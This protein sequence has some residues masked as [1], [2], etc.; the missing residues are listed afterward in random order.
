[1]QNSIIIGGR[2]TREGV[3]KKFI[4]AFIISNDVRVYLRARSV[5]VNFSEDTHQIICTI[6]AVFIYKMINSFVVMT[7][8]YESY[9]HEEL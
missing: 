3:T 7:M 8:T 9:R 1:M 6:V 4:C 2:V 5:K